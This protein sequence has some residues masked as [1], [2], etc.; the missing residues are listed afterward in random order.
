VRLGA[1]PGERPP[2]TTRGAG[3][4]ADTAAPA[5]AAVGSSWRRVAETFARSP[6]AIAGLGIIVL[7][8]LFCFA[9]PL[10]YRTNQ[11][12]V[13][14]NLENLPPGARHPLGT[15][16]SGY[17]ILGRLML[18]GQS[19]LELG[20]AVSL[21]SSIVGAVYGAVAGLAGGIVDAVMMRVVDTFLAIPALVL[22]LICVNL[23][24]PNLLAII[25]LLT[26]LSW[27]VT[28]RLVRGETLTL[29]TREYVQAA[30]MMGASR[31]RIVLRHLLPNAM[32][33]IV[34]NATLTIADAILTL[35]ALSY[36]GLGLPPPHA[37]W[38]TMLANGLNYLFDGYWWM[39]YPPAIILIITVMA[40]NLVG[41]AI[42]DA[43]DVRLR[44]R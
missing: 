12:T 44:R 4:A 33:V 1:V 7:V 39:V 28:A 3:P 32:G 43:L 9:G 27:L 29:R 24:T 21:G 37:D 2:A 35:S 41:D 8:T 17:D 22:L 25:L 40:F 23:F 15:D 36:L 30:Q 6:L 38:G 19:S 26:L 34:V 16:A 18:G 31:S 13:Q 5:S 20:L 10:L 11:I 42:R 14:L